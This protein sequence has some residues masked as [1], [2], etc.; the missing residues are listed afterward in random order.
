MPVFTTKTMIDKSDYLFS[1]TRGAKAKGHKG[2]NSI[3]HAM[4]EKPLNHLLFKRFDE[5]P[6]HQPR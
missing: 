4:I 3:V 6:S 1:G 2:L 5:Q